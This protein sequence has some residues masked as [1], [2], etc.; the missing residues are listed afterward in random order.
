VAK[1]PGHKANHSSSSGAEINIIWSYS[2][3][4]NNTT[5]HFLFSNKPFTSVIVWDII[6]SL[7]KGV[8]ISNCG[9]VIIIHYFNSML[10]SIYFF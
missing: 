1:W 6:V 7:T 8:L 10:L 9:N 4:N 2:G 3:Q 5:V